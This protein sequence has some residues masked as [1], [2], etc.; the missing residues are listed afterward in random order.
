MTNFS[1]VNTERRLRAKRVEEDRKRLGYL[2]AAQKKQRA[3]QVMLRDLQRTVATLEESIKADLESVW[4][5]SPSHFAF[6]MKAR[7]LVARRDNLK[8]TIAALMDQ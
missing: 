2:N 1:T 6:P 7:G 8:A 5:K 3:T 4:I